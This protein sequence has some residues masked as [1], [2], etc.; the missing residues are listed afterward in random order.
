[1]IDNSKKTCMA[2]IDKHEVNLPEFLPP[3][4]NTTMRVSIVCYASNEER[5][6]KTLMSLLAAC[7]SPLSERW[8]KSVEIMLIDNGPSS[9]EREKL[10]A[11]VIFGKDMAVEG[12]SFFIL[13]DGSN[14]GFGAGHNLTFSSDGS[15]YHLILNPDVEMSPNALLTALKFMAVNN[16]CGLVVPA[17]FDR[18]GNREYLCKRYPTVFDL[19]IRGFAPRWIRNLYRTR[20]DKYEM[21]DVIG[22]EVLWKPPIVSGCFMFARS[23]VLK[24]LKGFDSAYFL[25]FEDFDLSLRAAEVCKIAYVPTVR[26]IHYGGYAASKGFR[27]IF[28]FIR[29]AITFF[30]RHGWEWC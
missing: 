17:I 25:Y 10:E 18:N 8:I 4:P 20:L 11:M 23:S 2:N 27:H 28:M 30:N 13:N 24:E 6:K 12:I 1:M 9:I 19:L 26:I 3:A 14:L 5:L 21:R 15:D 16:D 7:I 22:D 29:S